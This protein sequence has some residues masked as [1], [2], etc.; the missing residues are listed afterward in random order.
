MNVFHKVTLQSLQKNKT[1]TVVTIIGIILSAAM[2]CAVTTTI[3]SLQDFM[4]RS[5]AYNSGSW[6]GSVLHADSSELERIRSSEQMEVIV[7]GN[8]VGY[9]ALEYVGVDLKPY[10]YITGAS[11]NYRDL[12]SV[13][14]TAGEYPKN[15]GEIL[16]PEHLLDMGGV[17]YKIGDVLTLEI[18]ERMSDGWAFGQE[19]KFIG[20]DQTQAEYEELVIRETRTYTVVG[21]YERPAFEAYDAAG[22][23]AI[24][25][26]DGISD[27]SAAYDVY[28]TMKNPREIY[29]FLQ[30]NGFPGKVNSDILNILG[31]SGLTAFYTVFY[32]LAAIVI[33]LI[34]FGSVS[35]IYNA[36][37]I[38][39]SERTKQFGLL[40]SIGATRRQIRQMVFF[41]A[42]AVSVIGIPVGIFVGIAGIGI[43]LLCIGDRFA[44]IMSFS[45]PMILRVPPVSIVIAVVVALVTVLISAWIPSKRAMKVS[46]VEAIRQ[47]NDITTEKKHT[48]TLRFLG[49][50]FGLPGMLADRHFSRNKKK[51]RTTVV[52]LFM[53]IVLFVSAASF[54]DYLTDSAGSIYVTYGFDVLYALSAADVRNPPVTEAMQ[55]IRSDETVTEAAY[56]QRDVLECEISM[57]HLSWEWMFDSAHIVSEDYDPTA[58]D[59]YMRLQV[60]AIYVEDEVYRAYLQENKL[61][62]ELYMNASAPL[63]VAIDGQ[64]KYNIRKEKFVTMN[65]LA[66]TSCEMTSTVLK[67]IDGYAHVETVENGDGSRI[68]RYLNLENGE[69]IIEFS[70]EEVASELTLR[71]GTTLYEKPYFI[72]TSAEL[73]LL[74]PFSAQQSV[75]PYTNTGN[76]FSILI[77]TPDHKACCDSL[78]RTLREN[79]MSD[80][81]L[82][83]FAESQSQDRAM[84]TII[85][86]FSYGF[87]VLISLIA[88]ANVF[89]TITTNIN[90]RRREFAMLKSVGMT[91]KDFNRMMNYECLLYGMKARLYGIPASCGVTVLIYQTISSGV[92]TGFRLPWSAIG[93]AVLSVFIVVSATMMYSMRKVR[94]ENPIDALRNENL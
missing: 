74:Y 14:I 88:A 85:E 60:I 64:T 58:R 72:D 73:I 28:F 17:S 81:R 8:S 16:L 57:D 39:V 77:R 54:T 21:F 3:A 62:E 53:S 10:L 46:A 4:Y 63:A 94:R 86:V 45:Q 11:E 56:T 50:M 65:T 87:I 51:Y 37:S 29:D 49:R 76:D 70:A 75:N 9:A 25:V 89:N 44:M 67:S 33:G 38:S 31:V 27:P 48:K 35:L 41:E 26:S 18:G 82:Y 2:I 13:H 15:S 22:Y 34:M 71:V 61:D 92:T 59:N 66:D 23:T 40:S 32:G 19:T 93:I 55:I 36:F 12:M 24:T 68:Y 91:S 80:S 90:L 79:G 6:Q 52:S 20:W 43:T 7:Y 84:V 5:L 1:R 69:E 42:F 78:S 83:D 30:E 47:T